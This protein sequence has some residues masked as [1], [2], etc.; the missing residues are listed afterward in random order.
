MFGSE[1]HAILQPGPEAPPI[2]YSHISTAVPGDPFTYTLR[3]ANT[4]MQVLDTLT[5][6][7]TLPGGASL[8]AIN[9]SGIVTGTVITWSATDL[10]A[11]DVIER[12]YVVSAT[13]SVTTGFYGVTAISGSTTV[14]AAGQ[15]LTTL[16]NELR[17]HSL[18]A[19]RQPPKSVLS[20]S[21]AFILI[22]LGQGS[23]A[24]V[25]EVDVR[26]VL[27]DNADVVAISDDGTLNDGE[28]SWR[29]V[30]LE[31]GK[32]AGFTVLLCARAVGDVIRITDYR[33]HIG[34]ATAVL[35]ASA[36]QT[37]VTEARRYLS[38]IAR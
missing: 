10:A 27:P 28:A 38:I 12:S 33:A 13:A 20:L 19:E 1:P 4:S 14:T 32:F 25:D 36:S 17:L 23:G 18:P 21:Q 9:D 16:V 11:G 31:A 26:A 30:D 8:I 29:A 22:N 5:I 35:G 6:I 37:V 2:V 3:I 15:L 7:A 34:D 24:A